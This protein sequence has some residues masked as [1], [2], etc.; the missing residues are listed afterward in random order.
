MAQRRVD[1]TT[2][3]KRLSMKPNRLHGSNALG[4]KVKGFFVNGAY[5][6]LAG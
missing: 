4:Q 6:K 2:G 1:G 5:D 3:P